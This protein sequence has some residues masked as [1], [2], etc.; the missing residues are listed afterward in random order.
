MEGEVAVP[1]GGAVRKG[2]VP[3]EVG[4][5]FSPVRCEFSLGQTASVTRHAELVGVVEHVLGPV[6]G[7]VALGVLGPP[8]EMTGTAGDLDGAVLL[9]MVVL[10]GAVVLGVVGVA[11][12][13]FTCTCGL[14]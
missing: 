11:L 4:E 9:G 6:V 8:W 14:C 1:V 2:A 3:K 10:I 12:L 13:A 5:G 7:V